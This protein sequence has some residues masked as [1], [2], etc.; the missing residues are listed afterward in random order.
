MGVKY[1]A[2]RSHEYES[3]EINEDDLSGNRVVLPKILGLIPS[4]S[5]I[6][7]LIVGTGIFVTPTGVLRGS[8]GSVGISLIVWVLGAFLSATGAMC[9]TEL[10]LYFR[11][12]GGNYVFL[13]SA[14]GPIVG[15]LQV[16]ITFFVFST[17]SSAI[18]SI[19]IVNFLLT[20]LIGSCS[21]VPE[22]GVKLGA[23]CVF[24]KYTHVCF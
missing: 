15:F 13:R 7:G 24:R 17:C 2:L 3:T 8:S 9:L 5:F 22:V 1:H 11:Q 6:F 23:S 10:T 14:Y 19:V 12:S 21:S 20:P 16:W 18:Q 4:I